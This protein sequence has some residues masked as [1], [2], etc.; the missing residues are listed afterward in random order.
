M[1][2]GIFFQTVNKNM[3]DFDKLSNSACSEHYEDTSSPNYELIQQALNNL[4]ADKDHDVREA[5]SK[6]GRVKPNPPVK[7][8]APEIASVAEPK[9][10]QADS[11]PTW[12][13]IT[14]VTHDGK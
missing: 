2:L 8:E 9:L 5:A 11:L 4:A 12:A 7:E 13:Q 10:I 6:A 3:H 14:E 1:F